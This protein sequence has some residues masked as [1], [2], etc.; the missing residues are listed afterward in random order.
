MPKPASSGYPQEYLGLPNRDDVKTGVISY[1]IAAHAADLAKQH[2][3]AQEWDDALSKARFEFRWRDQFALALDPTTAQ[4]RQYNAF[5]NLQAAPCSEYLRSS[6]PFPVACLPTGFPRRVSPS[7]RGEAGA[8]LL[9]VRP[10]VLLHAHHGR[11]PQV[12]SSQGLRNARGGHAGIP[13]LTDANTPLA[14]HPD[15]FSDV[16]SSRHILQKN[17]EICSKLGTGHLRRSLSVSKR[18][19]GICDPVPDIRHDMH[20]VIG[21]CR[22]EWRR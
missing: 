4:V 10:Q 18:I 1:K 19:H 21:A 17:A 20:F 22:K 3:R 5:C 2:P 8:L 12:R 7:G 9:H 16:L 14:K 11:H 6:V 15:P 13:Y